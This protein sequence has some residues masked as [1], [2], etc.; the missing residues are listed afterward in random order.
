MASSIAHICSI[1]MEF[2]KEDGEPYWEWL[3]TVPLLHQLQLQDKETHDC[4]H[5]D[6]NWGTQ[7]L[8]MNK[9]KKFSQRIQSK[10]YA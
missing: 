7:G 4:M 5:F 8:N 1:S 3:Y 9:L 10:K 2:I 6:P